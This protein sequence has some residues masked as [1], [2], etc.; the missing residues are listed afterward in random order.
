MTNIIELRNDLCSIFDA[1][2]AGDIEPDKCKELV[3]TA[4]KIIA[5]VKAELDY[6]TL[7][8]EIPVIEFLG[9]DGTPRERAKRLPAP[10]VTKKLKG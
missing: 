6:A 10:D 1:L 5:S 7:R 2:K 8:K 4:G 9:G 3:N